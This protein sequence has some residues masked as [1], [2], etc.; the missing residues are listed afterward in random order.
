[1]RKPAQSI[2]D[3]GGFLAGHEVPFGFPPFPRKRGK[4]GAR[5]DVAHA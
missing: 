5:S 4:D 3:E 1:M 2:E